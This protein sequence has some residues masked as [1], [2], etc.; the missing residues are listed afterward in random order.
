[1]LAGSPPDSR[2]IRATNPA[3]TSGVREPPAADVQKSNARTSLAART[4]T[5]AAG[6]A[7]IGMGADGPPNPGT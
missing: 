7:G 1:M 2:C 5:A 3:A 4:P 6:C